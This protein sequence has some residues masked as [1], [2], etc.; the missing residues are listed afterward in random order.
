MNKPLLLRR[1]PLRDRPLILH[2][3]LEEIAGLKGADADPMEV[4]RLSAEFRRLRAE[5]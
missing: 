1:A 4:A 3:L 5:L 2:E